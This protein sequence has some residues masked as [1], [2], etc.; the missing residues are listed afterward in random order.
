MMSGPIQDALN[1]QIKLEIQSAYAYLAMGAYAES[2]NLPGFAAWFRA[3]WREEL[4]HAEKLM[5]IMYDRGGRVTLQGIDKPAADYSSPLEVFKQVLAH[6]QK[7]TS[8]INKLYEAA[9]KENDYATQIEIQWFIKEQVEEEKNAAGIIE[10]LK[11][12]GDSGTPLLM[13]DR[14]LGMRGAK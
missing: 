1:N 7:V 10:Q 13:M 8:M 9:L 2:I 11:I 5:G 14:H 12:T 6:E 3:Q 4:G